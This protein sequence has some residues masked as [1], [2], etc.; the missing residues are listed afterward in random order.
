MDPQGLGGFLKVHMPK[1]RLKMKTLIL[2]LAVFSAVALMASLSYAGGDVA[3]GKDLFNDP[4][5][6]TNGNTCNS[7]HPAGRGLEHAGD[8]GR[9]EWINP[10][11]KWLS[12][13]DANN[14]CIMM[15]LKG[16]TIDPRGQM[17]QDLTAYIRSLARK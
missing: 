12:L 6:G 15:A 1:E 10:G 5:L 13:E 3:T 11:G 2:A 8:P 17:M 4:G 9:T 16:K 14:V 7:C